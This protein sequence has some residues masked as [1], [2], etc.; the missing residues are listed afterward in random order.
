[1]SEPMRSYRVYCYDAA[2]KMLSADWIEAADDEG[3]VIAARNAGFGTKCEIWEGKRLVA[4]LGEEDR[5]TA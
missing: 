1:M 5:R 3:A 4:Q 2:Q